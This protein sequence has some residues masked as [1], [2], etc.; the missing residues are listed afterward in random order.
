M[1]N[2]E[3]YDLNRIRKELLEY[4]GEIIRFEDKDTIIEIWID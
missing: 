2:K 3:G 1:I 4:R